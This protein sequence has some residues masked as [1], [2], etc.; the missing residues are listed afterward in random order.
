MRTEAE[1]ERIWGTIAE[2]FNNLVK[3][4]TDERRINLQRELIELAA[5]GDSRAEDVARQIRKLEENEPMGTTHVEYDIR[6][7][8]L[9]ATVHIAT[10]WDGAPVGRQ[11]SHPFAGDITMR[12]HPALPDRDRES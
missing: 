11:S 1:G 2:A 8:D 6:E 9:F 7:G 10:T 3:S 4:W 12:F 5:A